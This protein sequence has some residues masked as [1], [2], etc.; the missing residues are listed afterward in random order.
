MGI[1]SY[2]ACSNA[3]RLDGELLSLCSRKRESN[4]RESAPDIQPCPSLRY[5]PGSFVPSTFQGHAAKGRP[6]PIAALAASM[7]LNPLHADSTHLPD[8]THA[9]RTHNAP[10]S[11]NLQIDMCE[12]PSRLQQARNIHVRRPSRG[13]ALRGIWHGCQMRN[14]GPGT[15]LRDDPR[16]ST[17]AREVERSEARMPGCVSLPSFLCTS[18]E[19]RS[20]SRA[21]LM[22]ATRKVNRQNHYPK[23]LR[24]LP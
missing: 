2:A 13:V 5:G 8:G 17:G 11:K 24:T 4:Q 22:P 9:N 14:D 10:T 18:K 21:K 1:V 7:P 6:W 15:A 20:P 3:F 12:L 19:S 23:S 16:S